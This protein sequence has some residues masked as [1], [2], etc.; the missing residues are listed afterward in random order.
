M[1]T[2]DI[3]VLNSSN[4]V[5]Y[6][7]PDLTLTSTE[8]SGSGWI[9]H[10]NTTANCTLISGV[11]L[12]TA[13]QVCGIYSYVNGVFAVANQSLYNSMLLT[14]AQNSK[15]SSLTTSCANAITSGFTSSA[16]GT[17]YTYPSQIVDQQ[18]LSANVMSS[19]LPSLPSTWTTPQMCMSSSG[20]W[21]YVNH[22][23]AQIQQVGSDGKTAVLAALVHK[24]T[25]VNSVMAATTVA[26]VNAINW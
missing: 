26:Q 15:I 20:V 5:L 11:T 24:Q 17:I 13:S 23:A 19:L 22:T 3:I 9:D 10:K 1:S 18:N 6:A 25:L 12:P 2:V 8:A 21:S 16:L 4:L 14:P 7:E